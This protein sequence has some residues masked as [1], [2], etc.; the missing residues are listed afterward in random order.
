MAM[1]IRSVPVMHVPMH[2]GTSEQHRKGQYSCD[3][4]LV[5]D[6]QIAANQYGGR[7][8]CATFLVR[9][10]PEHVAFS[11]DLLRLGDICRWRLMATRRVTCIS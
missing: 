6:H 11:A 9:E 4:L 7:E 10:A 1:T 8:N 2:Q 3:V 5:P